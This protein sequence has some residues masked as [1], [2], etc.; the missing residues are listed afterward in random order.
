[1]PKVSIV[2][3]V[4]N[5]ELYIKETL[6]SLLNQTFK[7]FE[8]LIVN[9]ASTD[10]TLE[11]LNDYVLKDSR[12]KILD[13]EFQKGIVGGLNTAIKNS[14]G[15]YI[16]R[17]DADDIHK[18]DRLAL[19]VE[20]LDKHKNVGIVGGGYAPFNQSGKIRDLY[21]PSSPIE[22]AYKFI[23]NNYFVHPTVMFRKS[24]VED[25]GVYSQVKAED[26]ELFSRVLQKYKG[27][28]LHKILIDYREHSN[29]LS[30]TNA[31][32]IKES[33]EKTSK[34]N[35][36]FYF[37]DLKNYN[38]LKRYILTN[39]ISIR[40]ILKVLKLNYK[41]IKVIKKNYKMPIYNRY[42]VEFFI[43]QHLNIFGIILYKIFK[44]KI[45]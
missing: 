22:L 25:V 45:K 6:D 35:F 23:F 33:V 20:F 11:I 30:T 24:I 44:L 3:P 10:S 29:N 32:P 7:D 9:D 19:Q 12:I 17:A 43:K 37:G 14:S 18:K 28:N 5:G 4:Y 31:Y 39:T 36:L 27:Y 40:D 16:A 21:H 13:N 8:L 2:M 15:E 38:I 42:L 26:Y 41:F 34:D 1:M